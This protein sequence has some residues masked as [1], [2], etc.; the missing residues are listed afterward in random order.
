MDF[1]G[2]ARKIDTEVF[3]DNSGNI[4][5]HEEKGFGLKTQYYLEQPDKLIF[6]DEAGSNTSGANNNNGNIGGEKL[7]CI[8]NSHPQECANTKDAHFTVLGFKTASSEAVM[9]CIIFAASRLDYLWVPGLDP[10]TTWEGE[11]IEVRKNIGKGKRH[12]QGPQC[13]FNE[14]IVPFF[15]CCCESGSITGDLLTKML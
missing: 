3:L 4:V 14:K 8:G 2:I 7:S 13:T 1:A 15:C 12:P 10:F 5:E 11:E 6:V 9:C